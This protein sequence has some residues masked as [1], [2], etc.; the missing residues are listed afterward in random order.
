MDLLREE[1]NGSTGI[2][3]ITETFLIERF[4]SPFRFERNDTGGGIL[5]YVR[6]DI[7]AK[8]LSH[9]FPT[10]ESFFVEII[11]RRKKW[12]INCSY[13]PHKVSIKNHLEIIS[14]TL[15]IFT[16]KYENFLLLGDF[17]ACADD[18][19]V[20]S[21]CICYGLHSLIKQLT[22]YKNPR[23][24]RPTS[25]MRYLTSMHQKRKSTYAAIISL[26]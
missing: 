13:N 15:D 19:T 14:G 8:V 10:A 9:N 18:E 24:P 12:L 4:H 16:T 1:V 23:N 6:E 11:F 2:F 21:F 20:K 25:V 5:L 7:P 26:S 3:V 22:C 17:N